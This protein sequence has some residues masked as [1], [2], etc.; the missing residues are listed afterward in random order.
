MFLKIIYWNWNFAY[1][2]QNR[3]ALLNE[4]F[5]CG[6][7]IY[8]TH[9]TWIEKL[10]FV[11]W[12]QIFRFS[13]EFSINIFEMTWMS[14][15]LFSNEYQIFQL[16]L[17]VHQDIFVEILSTFEWITTLHYPLPNKE[18]HTTESVN[19]HSDN[20]K[21]YLQEFYEAK[22]KNNLLRIF[23]AAK[24]IELTFSTRKFR[25]TLPSFSKCNSII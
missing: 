23:N 10:V 3:I 12:A 19:M 9:Y 4:I 22:F 17:K 11:I 18:F 20:E 16:T 21:Y 13:G 1:I 24:F 2:Y 8:S 25:S 14:F 15:S 7:F 6:R 5:E